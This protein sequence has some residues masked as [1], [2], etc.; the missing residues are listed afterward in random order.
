[1][2]LA[3]LALALA[4]DPGDPSAT[5][6]QHTTQA[7]AP[8]TSAGVLEQLESD[9]ARWVPEVVVRS[10][11]LE[12]DR[13]S[14]QVIEAHELALK[15]LFVRL[16]LATVRLDLFDATSLARRE[17]ASQR[18]RVEAIAQDAIEAR[19]AWEL[20]RMNALL[21][22]GEHTAAA[23]Y[24]RLAASWLETWRDRLP[25]PARLDQASL[26]LARV[27]A[28][29]PVD[30][31]IVAAVTCARRCIDPAVRQ[32]AS[33]VAS[34]LRDA[35]RASAPLDP[36]A[37][38]SRGDEPAALRPTS[39]ASE[40]RPP[41][42]DAATVPEDP[43]EPGLRAGLSW[44]LPLPSGTYLGASVQR[45]LSG[46]LDLAVSPAPLACVQLRVGVDRWRSAGLDEPLDLRRVRGE[47]G[48]CPTLIARR[49][50]LA[51][52]SLRAAVGVGLARSIARTED[53]ER[54][55]GLGVHGRLEVP[56]QIGAVQFVPEVGMS[57]YGRAASFRPGAS[58]APVGFIDR[59]SLGLGIQL[60]Y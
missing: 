44:I 3:L 28:K 16:E 37:D 46:A 4:A 45:G 32:A 13:A 9:L 24:A 27:A 43:A 6:A 31:A 8:S 26:V 60:A 25:E 39:R 38:L 21:V 50:G 19:I 7:D 58:R 29:G 35:A 17:L 30:Q 57:P 47:L 42:P 10:R 34:E 48:W 5:T 40:P 36:I 41:E 11:A 56:V 2:I 20:D 18:A 33:D 22:R 52:V 55:Y 53:R 15:V 49:I 51:T 14:T 1:M 59:L 54:L 12:R 23:A